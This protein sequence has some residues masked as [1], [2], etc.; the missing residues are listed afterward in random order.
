MSRIG[1]LPIEIPE[2]VD[3]NLEGNIVT[4]KGPLGTLSVNIRPEVIIKMEDKK[5]FVDVTNSKDRKI[6]AFHGLSRTLINNIIV[7]VSKGF[8]KELEIHGTGYRAALEGR[9]LNLQ[10]GY[11][12]PVVVVPASWY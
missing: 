4:A 11:S 10:L 5:I 9:N 1:K 6:R 7:G 2:K 12:H 8:T 3:V